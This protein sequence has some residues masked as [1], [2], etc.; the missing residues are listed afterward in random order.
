M[1]E[2]FICIGAKLAE[3]IGAHSNNRYDDLT[4]ASVLTLVLSPSIALRHA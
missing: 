4:Y 3:E 1:N 2:Y